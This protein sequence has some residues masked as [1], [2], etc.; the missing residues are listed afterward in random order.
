MVGV[1]GSSPIAPTNPLKTIRAVI[2]DL[3]GTLV[4]SAGEIAAALNAALAELALPALPPEDVA[5]MVGRGVRGLGERALAK[6][7]ASGIDVDDAIAR[8]QRHY[9]AIVG[10]EARLFDGVREG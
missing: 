2:L 4:E 1:V 8:F 9:W 5:A 7:G 6:L 3:D 10:S